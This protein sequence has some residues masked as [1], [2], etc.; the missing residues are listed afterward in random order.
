MEG[1]R[2]LKDPCLLLPLWKGKSCE[3]GEGKLSTDLRAP[4]LEYIMGSAEAGCSAP[5]P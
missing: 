5:Q 2:E 3:V 4:G 1:L